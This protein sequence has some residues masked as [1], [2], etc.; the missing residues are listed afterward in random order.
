MT[1][2]ASLARIQLQVSDKASPLPEDNA[3]AALQFL[4]L[5][6]IA[7][8]SKSSSLSGNNHMQM[9]HTE[10]WQ[11]HNVWAGKDSLHLHPR[12]SAKTLRHCQMTCRQA[13]GTST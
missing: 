6:A 12:Q 2:T 9:G 4:H 3:R 5:K 13:F 11:L 7:S 8:E 10:D 1:S